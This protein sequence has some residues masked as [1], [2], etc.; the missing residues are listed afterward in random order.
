MDYLCSVCQR[1][2]SGDLIYFKDHTE[3]HIIE[4]VKHD[5]PDWV[6]RDG[7]CRQCVDY[8]RKELEGSVFHDAP[9]V[10]RKRKINFFIQ[11]L[12]NFFKV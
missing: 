2:V 3:K 9:C 1:K 12:K 7:I 4:L 5:H 10:L 8:Y 6:E 11:S